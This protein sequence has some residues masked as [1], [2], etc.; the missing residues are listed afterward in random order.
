MMKSCPAGRR[1]EQAWPRPTKRGAHAI[2]GLGTIR[3]LATLVLTFVILVVFLAYLLSSTISGNLFDAGF[4]TASFA[5]NRIYERYYDEV[6]LD[7]GM[8][9]SW[10]DFG[11]GP[12]TISFADESINESSD[13]EMV[14]TLS[15][16]EGLLEQGMGEFGTD[17]V[18]GI[19]VESRE[20]FARL[21]RE[22]IPPEYV[23]EQ[24]ETSIESLIGYLN[25]DE[26]TLSLQIDLG[27]PLERIGPVLLDYMDER[28]DQVPEVP[29]QSPDELEARLE[30]IYYDLA[31]G[32]LP[33][34]IPTLDDPTALVGTAHEEAVQSL[35]GEGRFSQ[36]SLDNLDAQENEIDALL[37]AG[38]V[39]GYMKLASRSIA[40]PLIEESTEEIRGRL[41]DPGDGS[42]PTML[43]LVQWAADEEGVT[44]EELLEDW[45]LKDARSFASRVSQGEAVVLAVLALASI[46]VVLVHLPRVSSGLFW[47]A[48]IA[49]A[50]GSI[51]LIFGVV[52][53][54]LIPSQVPTWVR[55]ILEDSGDEAPASLVNIAGDVL[56]S[57]VRDAAVDWVLTAVFMVAAGAAVL[58][59]AVLAK[60]L[61]IPLLSR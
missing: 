8:G 21:I 2:Y 16:D 10:I 60:K 15:H 48:G 57:M 36:E 1:R 11:S 33:S 23:Q 38:D 37:A 55:E 14:L 52:M 3:I 32:R 34:S 31:E 50:V 58:A 13:G 24:V 35:D 46:L 45:G 49:M 5:E 39:K 28:I 27:P 40:G 30:V 53:R 42:E 51:G 4:Y 25:G 17:F 41:L 59:V 6:L 7:E 54:A 44:R 9:E 43:D 18:G 20:D 19:G 56:Q 26:D 22:I 47:L 29:V 12:Y 61:G